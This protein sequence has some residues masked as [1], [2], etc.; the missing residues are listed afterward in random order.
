MADIFLSHSSADHDAADRIRSWLKRDRESWSVFLD[1]HAR[2]GIRAGQSWQDR[3]HGEL[4]SCRLVLAII[5]P[6]WLA[7][8]WCFAE[9]VTATFRGKGFVGIVPGDL[10]AGALDAAP[11]IVHERQRQPIDLASGAGWDE[12]L[13]ALDRSGLDPSRWFSIPDGVGPYPGFLAFE[14]KDAGVFFGRDAEIT[15]YL[16]A[17]NVLKA[18]DRA[19]ALVISGGSGSG[20][21]S[22]LKAG[23]IPRLR[24]Q[25][26]WLILAPFDLSRE[27]IHALLSVLRAAARTIEAEIDLPPRPPRSVEGL[28]EYLHDG[29]RLIEEKANAWVLLPLDQAEILVADSKKGSETEASRLLV[30]LGELLASRTRKLVAVLTIRTEFMPALDRALP[31]AVRLHVR[32]LRSISAMSEIIEKPAAR[33]G[34]QLEDGLTGRMVDDTRGA[35]ALPLLAYTLRE[36][37][38]K[39]GGNNLLTLAEY[40]QLGGVEGAI[41]KKLHEALTDPAPTAGELAA[42]RRCFVRQL[43]RVDESAIEGERYLRTAVPRDALPPAGSRL[44]DRLQEARLLVGGDDGTIGIAHE[45]LIRN[46]TDVPLQNWLA[47]DSDDRKLIES[48][49]SRLADHRDGGPLLSEK[50]L[51]DAKD[52]LERDRSLELDEPDLA[53]FIEDSV[54]AE[55]SRRRRQ[56]W[57]LRGAVAASVVFLL[58][59]IG[60][61]WYFLEAQEQSRIASAERDRAQ[62]QSELA[63]SRRL[64]M[65]ASD[66]LEQRLDLA[67]LIAVEASLG[68]ETHEARDSLLTGLQFNEHLVTH[69]H[70]HRAPVRSLDFSRDGSLLASADGR[71]VIRLWDVGAGPR[72]GTAL[73]RSNRFEARSVSLSPDG[74]TVVAGGFSYASGLAKRSLVFWDVATRQSMHPPV[75][76]RRDVHSTAFSPDGRFLAAGGSGPVRIWDL[77]DGRDGELEGHRGA[78]WSVAF[79]PQR[80]VLASGSDDGTVRL[81]NIE[82]HG[83]SVQASARVL[84]GHESGVWSVAFSSTGSSLA[85]ADRSGRVI[86]WNLRGNV[87]RRAA[88]EVGAWVRSV[89]F[90]RDNRYLVVGGDRGKL[91]LWW[92]KGARPSLSRELE[93]HTAK[94]WSVAVAPDGNTVATGGGSYPSRS[95]HNR[96]LLWN[97]SGRQPLTQPLDVPDR[98]L[99]QPAISADGRRIAARTQDGR[100]VLWTMPRGPWVEGNFELPAEGL[101]TLAF[102]H[103]GALLAAGG[104]DGSIRIWDLSREQ[105]AGSPLLIHP[106][107]EAHA[108]AVTA[109]TFSSDGGLLASGACGDFAERSSRGK[110]YH[111]CVEGEIRIWNVSAGE[112]VEP[113]PNA[114]AAESAAGTSEGASGQATGA[115]S[116]HGA[117]V[118]HLAFSPS[119]EVLASAGGGTAIVWDLAT[120]RP[121][122]RELERVA[123]LVFTPDARSLVTLDSRTVTVWDLVHRQPRRVTSDRALSHLAISPDGQSIAAAVKGSIALWDRRTL[124]RVGPNLSPS[125]APEIDSLGYD[126]QGN[127]VSVAEGRIL[128]WELATKDLRALACQGANRNLTV[129]EWVKYLPDKRYRVTCEGIEPD[130]VTLARSG[131]HDFLIGAEIR[132]RSLFDE[133]TQLVTSGTAARAANSVCWQGAI[134]NSAEEVLPACS[135]AVDL[136]PENGGYRDSRGVARA[137]TGDVDGAIADFRFYLEWARDKRPEEALELRQTWIR[138]LQAKE[139]PFDLATLRELE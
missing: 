13:D 93:G 111:D 119:G 126:S 121:L 88:F 64:A 92:L 44:I 31:S 69:L 56:T 26:D 20:K 104:A 128:L 84:E 108:S 94:V 36:L 110:I 112:L 10:P 53:Q 137:L 139:I 40:E 33:F 19:Q 138:A 63:L 129:E 27:P 107:I 59:A 28:T 8:R 123:E 77:V 29:L 127:L 86:I 23:L 109:L 6:D 73:P 50:P 66:F 124:E 85:S 106:P 98:K 100:L 72:G 74:A 18:P 7:S 35:D 115:L 131:R 57:R 99:T 15:E 96:V 105:G 4:Q 83:P 51:L 12:L 117:E 14:E 113:A 68:S 133:A 41:E 60:A 32:S 9:A 87:S 89:A 134:S 62:K 135:H 114:P 21:S 65:Q 75:V 118:G 11:P 34:I 42:F 136:E 61:V 130:P 39:Y 132:A 17:L 82:R 1:Q 90:A 22:L 122:S 125:R 58:V 71:G 49:R 67:L 76:H 103:G 47:E 54:A 45:R 80:Y 16:D 52:F 116:G 101:E 30:A 37:H 46:W 70:G 24:R 120:R 25:P 79:S 38:D 102:D 2:D 91:E 55:Q 78:I 48:L 5:T 95:E 43:V 3:L 97:L 81:W